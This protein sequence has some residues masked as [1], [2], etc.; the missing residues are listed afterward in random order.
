M[1]QL[2]EMGFNQLSFKYDW[3]SE[4]M[5]EFHNIFTLPNTQLNLMAI[6][7]FYTMN[8]FG[9]L[10]RSDLFDYWKKLY[11]GGI[12][13]VFKICFKQIYRVYQLVLT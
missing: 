8:D 9:Q 5:D 3:T 7:H 11:L 6:S 2:P 1:G 12:P 13:D 4:E 10:G